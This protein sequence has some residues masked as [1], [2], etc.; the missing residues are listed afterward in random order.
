MDNTIA[1]E[2]GVKD[3]N[4]IVPQPV[5]QPKGSQIFLDL[6]RRQ[7][8]EQAPQPTFD[9]TAP[10][11]M[12]RAAKYNAI[13]RGLQQLASTASLAMG[14]SVNKPEPDTKTPA[15]IQGHLQYLDK[16]KDMVDRY[17]LMNYNNKL[18]S[19]E[20]MYQD[21]ARQEAIDR[22]NQRYD[23]RMKY[24]IDKDK[25]DEDWE[26]K[27]FDEGVRRANAD[28][29]RQDNAPYVAS[30]LR[31]KERDEQLKR[32]MAKFEAKTKF[33]GKNF[34]LYDDAGREKAVLQPGEV[35]KI[36]QLI[37][38]DPETSQ[39]AAND[40]ALMRAQFGEGLSLQAQ[41]TIASYYWDKAPSVLKYLGDSLNESSPQG[42]YMNMQNRPDYPGGPL[43]IDG[44]TS[45]TETKPT[46]QN[47]TIDYSK[48]TY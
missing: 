24:Q 47:K 31:N 19:T 3:W 4:E 27:K 43:R 48:L 14:G 5:Q 22:E 45:G 28:D 44:N 42:D 25:A 34:R 21:A 30:A 37:L 23:E 33:D 15:Y 1:Y 46:A 36:V 2:Q 13:A 29:K 20:M 17:N 8:E 7:V 10:D 11:Y 32:D 9:T 26:K 35:E 39:Y 6:Y 40:I 12:K 16:Y 41:K 38:K 18:R